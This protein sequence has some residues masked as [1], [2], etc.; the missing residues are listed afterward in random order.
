MTLFSEPPSGDE[1]EI[2]SADLDAVLNGHR[3]LAGAPE[4]QRVAD[5]MNAL[6]S[7]PE[8]SELAGYAHY[9]SG[10]FTALLATKQ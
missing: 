3:P 4:V 8:G 6:T 1:P 9:P 2:S 10:A 5:A 7:P